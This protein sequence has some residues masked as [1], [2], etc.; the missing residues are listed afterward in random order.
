[1]RIFALGDLHLP[2]RDDKPM[3]VFGGQWNDHPGRIAR[4]WERSVGTRDWVLIPGD[5][6]WA[7]KLEQAADDLAYVGRLPGQA[8]MI[9]GNHDYWWQAIGKVRAALP[10]GV[11]AI[12]N[13]FL[14]I[15]GDWAVCGT[16]GWTLPQH[17]DFGQED[18]H[19]YAREVGRLEL[20]LAAAQKAGLT[21]A[22]VMLHYPPAP[23]D[24]SGTEFTRLLEDYGVR[25]CVYGH[26]HGEAGRHALHGTYRGVH[27]RLTAC[28]AIGFSPLLLGEVDEDGCLHLGMNG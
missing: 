3:D 16:R 23:A 17:P 7:L 26:L 20:S 4:N 6:S 24:G 13:D 12:Q 8:V 25:L 22:L 21:P 28:D 1:M 19:L 14:H 27:Y 11:Y 15:A 10:Q 2:G 5:I 18:E 9:R